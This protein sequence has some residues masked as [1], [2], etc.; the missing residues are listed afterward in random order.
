MKYKLFKGILSTQ[1]HM[2]KKTFLLHWLKTR[3]VISIYF[4]LVESSSILSLVLSATFLT[5]Q[6]CLFLLSTYLVK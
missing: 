2:I 1:F 4:T 5:V 6:N 3:P